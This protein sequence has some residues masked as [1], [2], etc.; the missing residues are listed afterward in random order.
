MYFVCGPFDSLILQRSHLLRKDV[1]MI[2]LIEKCV[3]ITK[4]LFMYKCI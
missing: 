1:E 4:S 2:N 3:A